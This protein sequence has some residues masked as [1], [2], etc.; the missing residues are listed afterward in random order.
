MIRWLYNITLF[1]NIKNGIANKRRID[2]VKHSRRFV[3]AEDA[4]SPVVGMILILGIAT[5][6]IATI[7]AVG[8]PVIDAARHTVHVQSI[9]NHMGI[10]QSDIAD[11]K[12]PLQGAGPSRRTAIQVG[13][14]AITVMPD[15]PTTSI[16]VSFDNG[17]VFGAP[18]T[19]GNIECI[20]RDD[21]VVFENG[22]VIV[23]FA[24]GTP[25]MTSQPDNM[26]ITPADGTNISIHLRM[27]NL[28]G[29]LSSVSG[30]IVSVD[31]R[32]VGFD[33][34]IQNPPV[35]SALN[36]DVTITITSEYHQAWAR[37]FEDELTR[38]GLTKRASPDNTGFYIHTTGNVVTIEIYG[39]TAGDDIYLSVHE[40]I[41]ESSVS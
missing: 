21:S 26:F 36:K 34:N 25:I 16:Q 31:S 22:A 28:T 23:R 17:D 37:F 13:G 18:L 39:K 6:M 35:A 33:E 15:A 14:G 12:G 1:L 4:V 24:H 3:N 8:I 2:E 29:P 27:V 19:V 9:Q 10:L 5:A 30:D 40:T 32:F 41:I 7:Y 20:L 38:A 11:L